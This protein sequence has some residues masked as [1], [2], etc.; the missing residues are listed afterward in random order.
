MHFMPMYSNIY[1]IKCFI[2]SGNTR[3]INKLL[4]QICV[5]LCAVENNIRKNDYLRHILNDYMQEI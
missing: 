2:P 5:F 4:L 3:L 1:F